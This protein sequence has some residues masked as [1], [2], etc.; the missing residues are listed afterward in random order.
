MGI[1]SIVTCWPGSTFSIV[2]VAFEYSI[3]SEDNFELQHYMKV[4]A[5]LAV[6]KTEGILE[7]L[8]LMDA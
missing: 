7:V 6:G 4:C 3:I 8:A 1:T 5:N 2:E